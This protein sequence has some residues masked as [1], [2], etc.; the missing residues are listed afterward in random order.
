[1]EDTFLNSDLKKYYMDDFT[2]NVLTC[3]DE[4]WEI[5]QG[6]RDILTK[7]NENSK[8]QS[9]YS[10]QQTFNDWVMKPSYI[11][12]TFTQEIELTIFRD[13]IPCFQ[14][15]YNID[16][17]T[18]FNYY[19]SY[20]KI[21]KDVKEKNGSNDLA[22]LTDQNYWKINSVRFELTTNSKETDDKFWQDIQT[23]LS[24]LT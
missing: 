11:D 10:H 5:S 12:I 22:C 7:I 17:E 15:R 24:G 18:R 9:L 14:A 8:I 20:P 4:F 21:D 16:N 13:V 2:K 19:Y 6:L 3:T 1:M 23:K